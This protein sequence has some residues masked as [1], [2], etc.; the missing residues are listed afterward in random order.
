MWRLVVVIATL[1]AGTAA[2]GWSDAG[3]HLLPPNVTSVEITTDPSELVTVK[4][5]NG[6]CVAK[7]VESTTPVSISLDPK[8]QWRIW[9]QNDGPCIQMQIQYKL[10]RDQTEMIV[11]LVA[12]VMIWKVFM[13][14]V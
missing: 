11:L 6:C 3:W 13:F 12:V 1:V 5:A 7:V 9:I 2:H 10:A 4:I 14:F 8:Q